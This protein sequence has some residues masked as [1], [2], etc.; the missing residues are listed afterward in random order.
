[1]LEV[2]VCCVCIVDGVNI[3]AVDRRQREHQ[4]FETAHFLHHVVESFSCI[5]TPS[6]AGILLIEYSPLW[7]H[8]N[9]WK[10]EDNV[11]PRATT[12]PERLRLEAEEAR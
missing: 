1:M 9:S 10:A 11:K 5:R 7:I 8:Y 12:E 6:H 3:R 2:E 4:K